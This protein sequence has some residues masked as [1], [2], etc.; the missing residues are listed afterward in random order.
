MDAEM[1]LRF[2]G[3]IRAAKRRVV[4]AS[5][6]LGTGPLEQELVGVGEQSCGS[7][8][9]PPDPLLPLPVLAEGGPSLAPSHGPRYWAYREDGEGCGEALLVSVPLALHKVPTALCARLLLR[10]PPMGEFHGASF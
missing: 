3:Q 9:W 4:M 8:A 6:Y 2:Q 1:S 10:R 5:L 7:R